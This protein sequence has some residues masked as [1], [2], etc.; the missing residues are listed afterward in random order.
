MCI[1]KSSEWKLLKK[2]RNRGKRLI[3]Q[4]LPSKSFLSKLNKGCSSFETEVVCFRS[5]QGDQTTSGSSCLEIC[6]QKENTISPDKNS[7]LNIGIGGARAA[8]RLAVS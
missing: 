4:H 8:C 3:I 1:K 6:E 7:L 2:K 5:K